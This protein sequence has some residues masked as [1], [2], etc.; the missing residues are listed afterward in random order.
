M[1]SIQR[2]FFKGEGIFF[3]LRLS[4]KE[5][6]FFKQNKPLICLRLESMRTAHA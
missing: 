6:H 1:R 2:I 4:R 5:K 3:Y